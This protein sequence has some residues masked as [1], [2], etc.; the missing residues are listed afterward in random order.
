VRREALENKFNMS[1]A[2]AS[3]D[4]QLYLQR[5]ENQNA[6]YDKSRK[7]YERKPTFKP[8]FFEP[9]AR[10]YLSQLH[11]IAD[12][13]Y[14]HFDTWL[15]NPPPFE[16]VT[17]VR[18]HVISE[19]LRSVLQAIREKQA[20]NI[21][22][23]SFSSAE[24]QWRRITP[25][26]LLFDGFR[27]HARAWCHRREE[28]RDFV[29]ARMLKMGETGEH[30]I[31]Q[32]DDIGWMQTVVHEIVANPKLEPGHRRVVEIEYGMEHHRLRIPTRLCLSYYFERFL[33]LDLDVDKTHPKRQQII[34]A[35]RDEVREAQ[36]QLTHSPE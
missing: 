20:V 2:Q 4:L 27:W 1:T 32:E 18:R 29:L 28:F 13:I 3:S 25:H 24:P 14:T 23:Q 9:T 12:G 30:R 19:Y 21:Q 26:A 10:H 31:R 8:T 11:S 17:R 34:L 6:E 7:R 16:A 33:G 35:N 36:H 5:T 15:G 22:Y